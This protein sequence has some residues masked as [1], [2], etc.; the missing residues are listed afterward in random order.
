V[1][2]K[3]RTLWAIF[4]AATVVFII[5][6][7]VVLLPSSSDWVDIVLLTACIALIGLG[8]ALMVLPV[9]R[10]VTGTIRKYLLLTGAAAAGFPIA[11]V[12]HNLVFALF[13]IEEPVFPIISTFVC[14]IGFLV[15]FVG[16]ILLTIK[17]RAA[18]TG[19][20]R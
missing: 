15:G 16:T 20:N 14:P 18:E 13:N 5:I 10:K 2:V 7:A 9:R 12:L 17:S 8:F 11:A 19:Q 6:M 1:A 3:D 4:W